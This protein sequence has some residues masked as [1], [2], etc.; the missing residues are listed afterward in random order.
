M[1]KVSIAGLS[2]DQKLA[3]II[4]PAPNPNIEF[5]ILFFTSLKKNATLAP[6]AVMDQVNKVAKEHL[7]V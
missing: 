3:A 6:N 5:N 4:T 7:A 2:K 1:A